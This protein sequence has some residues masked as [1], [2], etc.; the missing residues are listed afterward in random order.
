MGVIKR[1]LFQGDILGQPRHRNLFLDMEENI[2]IHY[3][4]LRIEL[5]RAEFE[6]IAEIFAKQSQELQAI[7]LEKNYQDGN[8]P[9][10]NQEDV[11]IWTESRLHQGIK[12]HPQRF[13]LEECSD[14]YHFHYR[15]Y[16][17]LIDRSEFGEIVNL[18]KDVDLDAPY[19]SKYSEIMEL[20]EVNDIDFML[21]AGCDPPNVLALLVANY[22]I[23]KIR[24]MLNYIGFSQ[25]VVGN[26]WHFVGS[27]VTVI[28]RA[29]KSR[30]TS[31]YK[32]IR[33]QSAPVR[34][35]DYLVEHSTGIDP[36]LLNKMKCQVLDVYYAI[37]KGKQ[38]SISLD[39]QMW[40][41][42]PEN[43]QI[44][45]PGVVDAQNSSNEAAT[46]YKNWSGLLARLN[47]GFVKPGKTLLSPSCQ[48]EL[49]LQ[50]KKFLHRD[51]ASY[52]AV[53]KIYLMGSVNRGEL[54]CYNAPF[55]HGRLVKLGSDIDILI[56][57]NPKLENDL[58]QAWRFINPE[59]S[60]HCAVYH[61]S[62]IPLVDGMK[63]WPTDYP[64]ID[65]VQHLI[66]A[67]VYLPSRGFHKE[68]DD[69][70]RK[71][72]AKLFYDRN[73]D[74][75]YF[76]SDEEATIASQL[77]ELHSFPSKVIVEKMKVSTENALYK[78]FVGDQ[79]YILKQ[80]KVSGNYKQNRIAEHTIYEAELVTQLKMRGIST[81]GIIPPKQFNDLNIGGFPSLLFERI[82]GEVQQRPE[83]PL[84]KVCAAL[85]A[86][87]RTQLDMP[88]SIGEA[89]QYD[90]T[91][92]IWLPTFHTYLQST[93]S[94][95]A[96]IVQAFA[97]LA[98][99][100]QNCHDGEFRGRLYARS[101]AIHNHGDVTPKN[102]IVVDHAEAYFFDFNNAF[103]GSR[104]I[105]VID[106]AFEFSLAEKYIHLADFKRFNTFIAEYGKHNPLSS[107]EQEDLVRWVELIGII[108]FTKEM[109]VWLQRPDEHLRKQRALAIADFV[110]AYREDSEPG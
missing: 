4:D 85:A 94:Y 98:P 27:E 18:F 1:V 23:P 81:A 32:R 38:L 50:V 92:M 41:Y 99:L 67:Y 11:R 70:L 42:T 61:I 95:P 68:K 13:S 49:E 48:Q 104:I 56:E 62:E 79:S 24:E 35:A 72:G 7:I 93:H 57:I 65:F 46:L 36:D 5:S 31:D 97:R 101:P 64:H 6:E 77:E 107:E 21:D 54:G 105:D 91:C 108:K 52:A 66:D 33:A 60:N 20:V 78:I 82:P 84:D 73:R 39:P 53:N 22:H 26:A 83:Y 55:V 12:Y 43:Q 86:I 80:F 30:T 19:A 16:K 87:H 90:D 110:L 29:D 109:R 3:R 51:V 14:G 103:F 2:H 74:G 17:L 88:L 71:F 58:P 102:V 59:A 63:N 28:V 89:F 8:L 15:N 34:L 37:K 10:A 69:F 96:D 47:L 75:I 76:R 40:L 25:E 106:G 44:V 45:F 9:N 100:A